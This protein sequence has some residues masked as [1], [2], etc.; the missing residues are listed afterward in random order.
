MNISQE[1]IDPHP[2][3]VMAEVQRQLLDAVIEREIDGLAEFT[4]RE[5]AERVYHYP[6]WF[7]YDEDE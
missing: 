5:F 7:Y 1:S 6:V 4:G 3:D 2:R